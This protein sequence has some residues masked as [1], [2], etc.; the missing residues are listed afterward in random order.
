MDKILLYYLH[1]QYEYFEFQF[2]DFEE[3]E[4]VIFQKMYLYDVKLDDFYLLKKIQI[5]IKLTNYGSFGNHAITW[6]K[7]EIIALQLSDEFRVVVISQSPLPSI[8]LFSA[9]IDEK[10]VYTTLHNFKK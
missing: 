3:Y 4:I 10:R 9:K 2:R 5:K 6:R 8:D 1:K 7:F